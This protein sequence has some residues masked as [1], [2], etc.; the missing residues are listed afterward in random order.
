MMLM[1]IG[2]L[3]NNNNDDNVDKNDPDDV[4]ATTKGNNRME[5]IIQFSMNLLITPVIIFYSFKT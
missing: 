2:I 5:L 4:N 3:I 1:L